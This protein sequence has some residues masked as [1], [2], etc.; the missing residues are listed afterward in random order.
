MDG[1]AVVCFLGGALWRTQAK[2][3]LLNSPQ[4]LIWYSMGN[5]E[6]I[7]KYASESRFFAKGL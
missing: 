5:E 6:K 7:S 3:K 2:R 4:P 1:F